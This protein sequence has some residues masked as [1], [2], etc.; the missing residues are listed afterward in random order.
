MI[1]EMDMEDLTS[2]EIKYE[3][4]KLA[5]YIIKEKNKDVGFDAKK[6]LKKKKKNMKN[7]MNIFIWIKL[8]DTYETIV[9]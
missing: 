7:V 6:I 8:I 5:K 9:D 3:K 2:S 4:E 1:Q